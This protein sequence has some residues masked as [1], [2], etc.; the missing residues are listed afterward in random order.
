MIYGKSDPYIDNKRAEIEQQKA[1]KLFDN[2]LKIIPFDGA[3]E[4]SKEVISKFN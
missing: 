4:V 3:H 1:Y 2:R